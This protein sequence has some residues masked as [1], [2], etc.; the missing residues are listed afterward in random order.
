[1]ETSFSFSFFIF[2][3]V[4]PFFFLISDTYFLLYIFYNLFNRDL[5]F[6]HMLVDHDHVNIFKAQV[7]KGT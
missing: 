7:M 2:F 5:F 3:I 1:M 4:F 6:Y